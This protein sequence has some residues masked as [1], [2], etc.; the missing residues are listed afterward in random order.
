M[1][2]LKRPTSWDKNEMA[3]ED[4]FSAF[5]NRNPELSIRAVQA[6]SLS[7]ATTFNRTNVMRSLV[8]YGKLWTAIVSTHKISIMRT[9]VARRGTH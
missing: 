5:M 1:Y 4:S 9:A 7:R 6:T 2:K 3:G 8:I